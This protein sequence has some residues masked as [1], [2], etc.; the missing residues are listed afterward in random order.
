MFFASNLMKIGQVLFGRTNKTGHLAVAGSAV[1]R[2][3][4][5]PA[6]T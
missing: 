5:G 1:L 3:P 2:W 6:F 4:G